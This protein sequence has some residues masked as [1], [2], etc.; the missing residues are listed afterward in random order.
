MC[1]V[2]VAVSELSAVRVVEGM[3]EWTISTSLPGECYGSYS[4]ELSQCTIE[5]FAIVP[6]LNISDDA[7]L[8]I[9]AGEIFK[10]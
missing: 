2:H 5:D 10:G 9:I 6:A 7:V 3:V 1:C 4:L 8:A